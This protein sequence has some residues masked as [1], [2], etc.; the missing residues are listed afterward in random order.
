MDVAPPITAAE[1]VVTLRAQ[2][3]ALRAAGIRALSLFGSVARGDARPDSDIDLVA[4]FDPAAKIDLRRVIELE[5]GLAELL[6]RRVE[7][8]P[9]PVES[10]RLRS[11]VEQDRVRAF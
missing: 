3:P 2:E 5:F 7:L 11:R 8:L 4:E 6:G 1:V 9:E 10:P